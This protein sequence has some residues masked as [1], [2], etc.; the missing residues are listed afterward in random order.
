MSE[1]DDNLEEFDILDVLFDPDNNDPIVMTGEDGR[2][3]TFEQVAIIPHD[4]K[5][6][7][8]LKPL[9]K[10]EGIEDDQAIV[11]LIDSD[12]EGKTV[13]KIELNEDTAKLVFDKYIEL[14]EN[15]H[16]KEDEE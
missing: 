10:I 9:D 7:C 12:D 15:E 6:Y 14:Y 11:F 8:V 1:K 13:L 4:H 16:K 5:V 2:E 3:I